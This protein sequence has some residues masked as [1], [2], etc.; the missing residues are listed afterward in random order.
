M[1]AKTV[2]RSRGAKAKAL[3][4][5]SAPDLKLKRVLVP[6]DFS[7]SSRKAVQYAVSFARQFDAEILLLHVVEPMPA[8]P[9]V[10]YLDTGAIYTEVREAAEKHL[11]EW[12]QAAAPEA[13]VSAKT[14]VGIAYHQIIEAADESKADLIVIGTHGRTGLA[15]LLMGSTAER[16]VREA[17]CPVLVVRP[18]ERDFVARAQAK[19]AA[20]SRN[21]NGRAARRRLG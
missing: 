9:E 7:E 13:R 5:K 19:V 3:R 11:S 6:V 17:G 12:R 2:A 8:P 21:E 14:R 15:H 16:V 10:V 4:R 18:R 20:S 1:N